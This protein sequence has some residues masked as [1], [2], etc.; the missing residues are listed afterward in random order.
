MSAHWWVIGMDW[1]LGDPQS[2]RDDLNL[3]AMFRPSFNKPH[4][5]L[6]FCFSKI[7]FLMPCYEPRMR[8]VIILMQKHFEPCINIIII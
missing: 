5:W 2:I 3:G 7:I 8:H 6:A 4:G 1:R